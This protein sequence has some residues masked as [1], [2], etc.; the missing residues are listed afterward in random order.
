MDFQRR[1]VLAG[2]I[3][4]TAGASA[5]LWSR[6]ADGRALA[7]AA[8]APE[9]LLPAAYRK[10][11]MP[12]LLREA[13]A[14][15]DRHDRRVVLRD[16]IGVVD[17]T[18]PSGEPRFQIVDVESGEITHAWLVSHGRGSDPANTGMV[19]AFSN[20]P[21]SNASSRGAY[22][23]ANAYVG[24]HGRSRRLLGLDPENSN[25]LERAIVLHGADY[26]SD[27]MARDQNRV[28]RSLGCFA[29]AQDVRD[30]MLDQLGEG[31]L[32]Y[33]GQVA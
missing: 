6:P 33:C 22:L 19:Q 32:L 5:P 27:D 14:A 12:P 24:K 23:T 28:G 13:M 8:G 31:R 9:N 1:H 15:L 26:V 4:L 10:A 16:R 20:V 11:D 21:E 2:A 30:L 29:V 18:R 25:A 3:A 7:T 17:F